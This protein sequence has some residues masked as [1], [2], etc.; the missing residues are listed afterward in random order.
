MRTLKLLVK[1]YEIVEDETFDQADGLY[2]NKRIQALYVLT[3]KIIDWLLK[4][5][6]E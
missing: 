2:Q 6:K 1:A 4:Q 3:K 5:E